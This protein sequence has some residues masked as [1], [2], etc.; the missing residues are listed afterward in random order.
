M[1]DRGNCWTSVLA[2]NS[3]G[4]TGYNWTLVLVTVVLDIDGAEHLLQIVS[5]IQLSLPC[6]SQEHRCK[7]TEVCTTA[8]D[9]VLESD[10]IW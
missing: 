10:C 5:H 9:E 3:S 6:N 7:L 2:F 8:T 1:S 4:T